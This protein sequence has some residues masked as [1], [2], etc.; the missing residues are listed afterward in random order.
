MSV[1]EEEKNPVAQLLLSFKAFSDSLRLSK[2][3][4]ATTCKAG[5]PSLKLGMQQIFLGGDG[6]FLLHGPAG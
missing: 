5:K 2:S 6:H 3:P 1:L 4:H